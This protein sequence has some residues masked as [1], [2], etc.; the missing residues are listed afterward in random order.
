M[1]YQNHQEF[2]WSHCR[3]IS[4]EIEELKTTLHNL[5]CPFKILKTNFEW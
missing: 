5:L 1:E 2:S 4:N 3:Y